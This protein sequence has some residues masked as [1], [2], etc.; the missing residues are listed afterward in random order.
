MVECVSSRVHIE[1]AGHM[2]LWTAQVQADAKSKKKD[3]GVDDGDVASLGEQ[4]VSNGLVLALVTDMALLEF[5]AK[6]DVAKVLCGL[7]RCDP[8]SAVQAYVCSE[9]GFETIQALVKG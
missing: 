4:L 1:R 2:V 8:P 9:E 5:E 6:K 7:L 3:K